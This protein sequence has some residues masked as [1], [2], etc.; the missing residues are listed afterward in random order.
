MVLPKLFHA[1][2]KL[3]EKAIDLDTAAEVRAL[4]KEAFPVA[5]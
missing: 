3:A 5:P 1:R 2:R 4:V